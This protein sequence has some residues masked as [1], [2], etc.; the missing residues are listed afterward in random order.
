LE[1]K[2]C[3]RTCHPNTLVN[4]WHVFTMYAKHSKNFFNCKME[5]L[6]FWTYFTSIIGRV[7]FISRRVLTL[8]KVL[9]IM[10]SS[11]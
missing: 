7:Y 6:F 5:V 8:W 9:V 11:S 3:F 4:F 10:G 1:V 2:F